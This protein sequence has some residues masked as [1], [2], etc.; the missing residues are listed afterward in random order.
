MRL[1]VNPLSG[2][3]FVYEPR[4]RPRPPA[5]CCPSLPPPPRR[6]LPRPRRPR[7]PGPPAPPPAAP[8]R[9][10]PLWFRRHHFPR[11][12][13]LP[14]PRLLSS[15]APTSRA[16]RDRAAG[17]SHG[18]PG[19]AGLDLADGSPF[20]ESGPADRIGT[21][22]DDPAADPSAGQP[23]GTREGAYARRPAGK[24]ADRGQLPAYDRFRY[25]FVAGNRSDPPG[26]APAADR[27]APGSPLPLPGPERDAAVERERG[28]VVEFLRDQGY[29]E[30]ERPDH[31]AVEEGAPAPADFTS[32]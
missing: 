9:R 19:P 10:P 13:G 29:F 1:R 30:V 15:G 14:R 25:I 27:V 8:H 7:T 26:R 4:P 5:S 28:R 18:P 2:L 11:P 23:S 6:L 12:C 17:R 16:M 20:I 24:V 3:T 22:P 31:L 21:P 32:R